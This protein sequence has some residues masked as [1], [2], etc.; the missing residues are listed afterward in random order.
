MC[1]YVTTLPTPNT[2]T[3][4]HDGQREEGVFSVSGEFKNARLEP[5]TKLG[6]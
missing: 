5:S 4:T 6:L 1:V 3:P 2:C